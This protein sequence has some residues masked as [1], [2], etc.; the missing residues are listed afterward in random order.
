MDDEKAII[1]ISTGD[2]FEKLYNSITPRL[3]K[4]TL[5]AN[6]LIVFTFLISNLR[7]QT[8]I[9]ELKNGELVNEIILQEELK[10]SEKIIK[11]SIHNL[12]KVGLM[13]KSSTI[14][15]RMFSVTQTF[16]LYGNKIVFQPY[17]V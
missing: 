11:R 14:K 5:S 4:T 1:N 6:E 15:D 12:I 7:Y 9:V 2:E 17:F 13:I 8:G 10:L 3:V 16:T